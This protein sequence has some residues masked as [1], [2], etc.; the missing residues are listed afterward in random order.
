[1]FFQT[2]KTH[3]ISMYSN[4]S[5]ARRYPMAGGIQQADIYRFESFVAKLH[6]AF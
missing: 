2:G 6:N 4:I 5:R 3:L 1:M